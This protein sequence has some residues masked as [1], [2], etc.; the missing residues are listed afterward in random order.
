M[1]LWSAV[2]AMVVVSAEEGSGPGR[3]LLGGS[4]EGKTRNPRQEVVLRVGLSSELSSL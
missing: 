3:C 4:R 2:V 1:A